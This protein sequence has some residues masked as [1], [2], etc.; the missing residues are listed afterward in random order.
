MCVMDS[1]T[2][3]CA[4]ES[5]PT[6]PNRGRGN[7]TAIETFGDGSIR[8]QVIKPVGTIIVDKGITTHGSIGRTL[9]KGVNMLLPGEAFSVKLDGVVDKLAVGGDL[10]THGANVTTYAM[11]GGTVNAIDIKGQVLAYGEDS[12]AALVSDGGCTPL[13][14]VRASAKAGKN[15][16]IADGHVSDHTG[17]SA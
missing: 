4:S 13:T 2:A 5:A 14:N 11:E 6:G 3:S 17:L 10:I 15:L 16:L 8:I 12:N 7:A 1:R 9:V